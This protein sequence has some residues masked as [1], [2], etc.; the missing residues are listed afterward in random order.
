MQFI[1]TQAGGSIKAHLEEQSRGIASERA[2]MEFTGAYTYIDGFQARWRQGRAL[3]NRDRDI[4]HS[5]PTGIRRS[6]IFKKSQH[7]RRT[8]RN[9][10]IRKGVAGSLSLVVY[11]LTYCGYG[12]TNAKRWS[13]T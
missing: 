11:S 3:S 12:L 10:E 7:K 4:M 8:E 6:E 2:Q 13:G 1:H 5:D 9:D